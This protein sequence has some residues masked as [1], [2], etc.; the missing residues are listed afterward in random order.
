MSQY[1]YDLPLWQ[2]ITS[3]W[4]KTKGAKGAIWLGILIIIVLSIIAGFAITLLKEATP[5]ISGICSFLI[6]IFLFLFMVGLYYIG[7]C[8]A[9]DRPVTYYLMFRS[10][11]WPYTIR[12]LGV[13]FLK[14]IIIFLCM[15]ILFIP[16]AF[17]DKTYLLHIVFTIISFIA[18][19][20]LMV[21]LSL[22]MMFVLVEKTGPI[23]ALELSWQATRGNFWNLIGFWCFM[24]IIF[25]VSA[26]PLG[27]GLIWAFP[28]AYVAWGEIYKN[29]LANIP[30]HT[31]P[32]SA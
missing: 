1:I 7:A 12:I 20:Y 19:I 13:Y 10:L 9:F 18:I 5:L 30:G 27:I 17:T 29:L 8:R 6:E 25:V 28:F 26:I 31:S 4:E 2:T 21:R 11:E 16:A 3:A 23:K 22:A 24:I 32:L 14:Y 15:L